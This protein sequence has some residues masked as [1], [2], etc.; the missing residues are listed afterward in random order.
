VVELGGAID[1]LLQQQIALNIDA[2]EAATGRGFTE[3]SVRRSA[4]RP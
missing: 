1:G 3:S 4:P 2:L